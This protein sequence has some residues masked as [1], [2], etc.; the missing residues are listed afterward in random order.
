MKNSAVNN[1]S[2]N[3]IVTISRYS[4]NKKTKLA[5]VHNSGYSSLFSF[6]SNCLIGDFAL[7]KLE[8]PVKIRLLYTTSDAD[9]NRTYEPVSDFIPFANKPEII[10]TDSTSASST[11]C[12]SFIIARDMVE[13]TNFNSL[14]LYS[15]M[16]T[17]SASDVPNFSAF[18]EVDDLGAFSESAILVVDWKLTIVNNNKG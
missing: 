17:P 12:Y 13:N 6:L 16:A 14:G 4:K 1:L 9:G 2:Y 8:L 7:A 10:Y 18:C 5:Q 15:D 3:G 11:V